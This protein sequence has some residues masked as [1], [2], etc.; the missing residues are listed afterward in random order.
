MFNSEVEKTQNEI[1]RLEAVI[2]TAESI[3]RLYENKDFKKVILEDF[4][5]NE[6]AVNAQN[7][8]NMRMSADQRAD[9][10][11]MAQAAGYFKQYLQG[12]QAMAT[13]ARKEIKEQEDL[14]LQ[15]RQEAGE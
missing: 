14:L 13:H 12:V 5:V 8:V 10:L 2:K 15:L 6:C 7:S 1:D 9:S 11:A 3:E 4:L